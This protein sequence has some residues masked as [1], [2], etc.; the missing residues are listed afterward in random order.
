MRTLLGDQKFNITPLEWHGLDPF[1]PSNVIICT[2]PEITI[3]IDGIKPGHIFVVII[4]AQVALFNTLT[5]LG[6]TIKSED[7]RFFQPYST[8]YQQVQRIFITIPHP[9]FFNYIASTNWTKEAFTQGLARI[10][11]IAATVKRLKP[12]V[13]DSKALVAATLASLESSTV[14]ADLEKT[15]SLYGIRALWNGSTASK[16]GTM[17]DSE[18]ISFEQ[19]LSVVSA[20]GDRKPDSANTRSSTMGRTNFIPAG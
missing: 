17:M 6:S 10:C 13:S 19:A 4:G 16:I 11:L 18:N 8:E 2:T 20:K 12:S 1:H 7:I 5:H 14:D 9:G 3:A 15:L